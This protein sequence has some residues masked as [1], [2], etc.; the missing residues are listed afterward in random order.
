MNKLPPELAKFAPLM[1]IQSSV[2]GMVFQY[3]FCLLM[4]E[5]GK[6]RYVETIPGDNG[7]IYVFETIAGDRFSVIKPLISPEF[8]A[9]L[10]KKLWEMLK[11]DGL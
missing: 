7:A 11:K 2:V 9:A 10:I 4:T 3:C 8:E 6:M 1:D 5:V